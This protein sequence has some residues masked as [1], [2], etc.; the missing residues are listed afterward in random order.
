MKPAAPS[1]AGAARTLV[2]SGALRVL[3]C[4]YH[5]SSLRGHGLIVREATIARLIRGFNEPRPMPAGTYSCPADFGVLV[6]ARF[7]YTGARP[8]TVQVDESGCT[9]LTN[10]RVHRWAAYPPGPRL[11][12]RLLSLTGCEAARRA[13]ACP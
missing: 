11:L 8:D 13:S 4:R 6:T 9:V 12:R 2:P 10:G 3:L 7:V 1:S 5:F